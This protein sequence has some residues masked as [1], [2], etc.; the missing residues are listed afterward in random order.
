MHPIGERRTAPN[1]RVTPRSLG[2]VTDE[3]AQR[4]SR[5]TRR[6]TDTVERLL[7]DGQRY[8][9]LSVET[10]IT[11]TG[12]SR[13]TFY[14]YYRDKGDLLAAIGADVTLDLAQA[15][16]QWFDFPADGTK[17]DLRAALQPLFRTYR[18]HRTVLGAIVE[19]ASYDAQIREVH[20]AL[21]ARA[22]DGLREQIGQ[23][24]RAGAA[25]PALDARRSAEWLVW[26]LERGLAQLVA[27]ASTRE[28][29]KLLDAM[30][31]LVWR[32][33]YAGYRPDD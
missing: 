29:A 30:T 20:S 11:D 26:M 19:T 9:D 6:L 18:R 23:A 5:L 17:A 3:H 32:A 2:A 28:V 1:R 10:L 7:A 12:I 21:V 14:R 24:Q 25:A 13:Y 15:G 22:A 27:E 4:R 33:L 8:A 16:A 31:E